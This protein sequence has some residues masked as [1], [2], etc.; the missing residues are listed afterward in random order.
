MTT[1]SPPTTTPTITPRPATG[2]TAANELRALHACRQLEGW[3]I[4][5]A[6]PAYD[7]AEGGY[8]VHVAVD[9]D[10]LLFALDTAGEGEW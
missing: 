8:T 6:T 4:H 7:P 3:G 9:P 1:P 5:G 2:R 10:E